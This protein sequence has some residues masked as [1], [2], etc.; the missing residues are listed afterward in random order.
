MQVTANEALF[1]Q[2]QSRPEDTALIFQGNVLTYRQLAHESERVAHG[3]W[4]SGVRAGDRV[5]LH[6]KNRPEMLVAY[7]ECFRLGAIAAPFRTAFTLAE[8]APMLERL[9]PAL[10]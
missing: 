5:V 3:L 7:Y 1:Q 2:A 4:A 10:Y 9:R 8:L 6:M